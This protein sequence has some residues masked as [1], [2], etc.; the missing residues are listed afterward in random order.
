LAVK[1]GAEASPQDGPGHDPVA[2]V[3]LDEKVPLA[4]PDGAVKV[5]FT[6]PTGLPLISVTEASNG[7]GKVVPTGP[8]WGVPA[9]ALIEVGTP[10]ALLVRVNG[11]ELMAPAEVAVTV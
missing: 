11:A 9:T 5:T 8:D 6:P 3:A 1:V 2:T 10:A 7:V 4:P